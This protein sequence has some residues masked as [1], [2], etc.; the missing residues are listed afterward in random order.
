MSKT[1]K[2]EIFLPVCEKLGHENLKTSF[3]CLE[4]SCVTHKNHGLCCKLCVFHEHSHHK[5]I[6][7][8]DFLRKIEVLFHEAL[9]SLPK[10]IDSSKLS[11]SLCENI[12]NLLKELKKLIIITEEK[13]NM[14]KNGILKKINEAELSLKTFKKFDK[15]Y[16]L[17]FFY[18][19]NTK[20]NS[21]LPFE[22]LNEIKQEI[23]INEKKN[24]FLQNYGSFL[25]N[26]EEI[27]AK[28][29]I[30]IEESLKK[31][32]NS[33]SNEISLN[34]QS[35]PAPLPSKPSKNLVKNYKKL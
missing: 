5:I 8:R 22:K 34:I 32:T 7:Y 6:H 17:D 26:D 14:Y 12:E 4:P 33:L 18:S 24:I 3:L 29:L 9:T 13:I 27:P 35:S 20:K 19:A 31:L 2:N 16:F 10:I 21:K 30:E 15:E 25:K 1:K 11:F 28:K 23:K